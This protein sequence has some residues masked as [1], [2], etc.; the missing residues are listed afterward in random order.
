MKTWHAE[1]RNKPEWPGL[2]GLDLGLDFA[3]AGGGA[4]SE[5]IAAKAFDLGVIAETCGRNDE[6]LK[7]MPP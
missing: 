5:A 3:N 4:R 1:R 6:I 2:R 7:L